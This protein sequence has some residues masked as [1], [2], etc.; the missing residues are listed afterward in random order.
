MPRSVTVAG[1][2]GGGLVTVMAA[3]PLCPSLVAVMVPEPAV[4]PVTN[5][6]PLTV[7]MDPLLLVQ[8]IE[9]PVSTFPDAS[10]VVAPS[11]TVWPA[12]TLA[13]AGLTVTVAT[14]TLETEK[15]GRA[16]V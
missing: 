9:R 2:G 15:I 4:T 10:L 14:G 8:T 5:P 3:L 1:E 13:D 11:C 16:H 6:L 7:A 12:S